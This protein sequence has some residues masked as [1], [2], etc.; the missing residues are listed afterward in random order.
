MKQ[1]VNGHV[2]ELFNREQPL[3]EQRIKICRE[4]KLMTKDRIFGDICDRN[5]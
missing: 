5:K 4:C 3:Y 1:I 2:K